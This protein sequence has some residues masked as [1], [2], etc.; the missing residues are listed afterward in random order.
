ME[1]ALLEKLTPRQYE[2]AEAIM[3]RYCTDAIVSYGNK[4]VAMPNQL[5]TDHDIPK[6]QAVTICRAAGIALL[7]KK[8]I[9]PNL[10][11]ARIWAYQATAYLCLDNGTCYMQMPMAQAVQEI[12]EFAPKLGEWLE[13]LCVKLVDARDRDKR[14]ELPVHESVEWCDNAR[15]SPEAIKAHAN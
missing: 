12:S 5:M 9:N 2:I 3:K 7:T 13:D 15:F 4:M 10:P 14:M 11:Y 6:D 1:T 8:P